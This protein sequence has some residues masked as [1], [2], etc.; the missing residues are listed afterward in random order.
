M[1]LCIRGSLTTPDYVLWYRCGVYYCA[2]L[3]CVVVLCTTWYACLCF[4]VVVFVCC[5]LC[6]VVIITAG[7]VGE[8][9]PAGGRVAKGGTGGV[10]RF[11]NIQHVVSQYQYILLTPK[12]H[13][14]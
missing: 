13:H 9:T 12:I 4:V 5:V 8:A 7:G 10:T 6:D 11:K 14:P 1:F 2:A 3:L